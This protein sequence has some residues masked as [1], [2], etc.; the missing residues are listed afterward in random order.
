MDPLSVTAGVIAIV[1]IV[2][3]ITST[4][5]A[6]ITA[7]KDA[8]RDL[9]T[10]VIEVESIKCIL[11]ILELL[12]HGNDG[13]TP[14]IL[15]KLNGPNGP[16]AGCMGVLAALDSLFPETSANTEGGKRRKTLMSLAHLA[17]PFKADKARKY[18]EDL[19]IYKSTISLTLTSESS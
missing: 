19:A 15:E 4:C 10:I 17:W 14:A 7:V 3:R 9:R 2:D 11:G 8:P 6:Y 1:Q 12:A 18:L 13:D 16:L 5:R